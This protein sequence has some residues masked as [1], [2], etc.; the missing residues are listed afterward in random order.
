MEEMW[1][2][3]KKASRYKKAKL[4]IGVVSALLIGFL[5]IIG[6]AYK[7]GAL[8]Y[9]SFSNAT[10]SADESLIEVSINQKTIID[11][12]PENMDF[13]LLDPGSIGKVYNVTDG[14]NDAVQLSSF[15]IENMGSTNITHVWL[16]VTQPAQNPFGSGFASYYDPGNWIAVNVTWIKSKGNAP[17]YNNSMS[18]VDRIEFNESKEL[19]YLNTPLNTVSYGRLRFANK[20]Y[21]W[22]IN[23]T[24]PTS[25]CSAASTTTPI[26]LVLGNP[27]EP[28]NVTD[29][30][31]INLRDGDEIV[32]KY[33]S[34]DATTGYVYPTR[35]VE[36]PVSGEEYLMLIS[37]DCSHVRLVKWNRDAIP[38]GADGLLSNNGYVFST[39]NPSQ[40]LLPGQ[41]IVMQIETRVPYGVV[42][43]GYTG[44]LTVI[45]DTF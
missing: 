45:A 41:G 43:A 5:F 31:D 44:Y 14:T 33:T 28:H 15:E 11:I 17:T 23:A 3:L 16:N 26:W 1:L 37:G 36:Y 40:G 7:Q 9:G 39:S 21:F 30:G 25:P 13:G 29:T 24:D 10:Y 8:V 2:N 4:G 38:S 20:E 18:Y 6:I 12:T 42:A 19:V 34:Y 22:A 32:I 27:N 35:A